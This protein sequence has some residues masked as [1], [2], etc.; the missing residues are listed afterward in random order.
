M[1]ADAPASQYTVIGKR[2]AVLLLSRWPS[3][4]PLVA[5]A[6]ELAAVV[7]VVVVPAWVA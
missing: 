2:L 7:V 3:L 6:V 1:L 5:W 4:P